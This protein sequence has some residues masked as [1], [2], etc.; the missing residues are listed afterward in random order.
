MFTVKKYNTTGI[1]RKLAF[2]NISCLRLSTAYFKGGVTGIKFK[3]ISCLR[4]SA[5]FSSFIR[6]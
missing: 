4:L 5:V 2:K 1:N 3:N 6:L